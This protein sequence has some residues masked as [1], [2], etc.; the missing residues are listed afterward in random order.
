MA[1]AAL[2]PGGFRGQKVEI[3]AEH[4]PAVKAKIRA[5]WKKFNPD[6]PASDMPEGIRADSDDAPSRV[7]RY[8]AGE[9]RG[10]AEKTSEG[11]LRADAVVTRVGIFPYRREDGSIRRELRPPE[12]VFR[13]DSLRSLM[14][15]PMTSKHP[16]TK[17][18][19]LDADT[20]KRF[21]VGSTGET[22]RTDG[23]LV[24]S[25]LVI[26]DA[27][28]VKAVE[29][30]KRG[31]SCGYECDF[32]P[33]P[34]TWDGEPY[35]GVQRNIVYNHVAANIEFPRA[36]DVAQ[37]HLDSD[38]SPE[39]LEA[40][41]AVQL[42]E[43][44]DSERSIRE[45]SMAD[46][47][48]TVAL[49]GINYQASPEVA[50]ALEKARKD[51]SDATTALDKAKADGAAAL[52]SLKTASETESKTRK[53]ELD[54]VTAE[55]DTLKAKVETLEK[56]RTDEI[57]RAAKRRVHLLDIARHDS[58]KML[59]EKDRE[60]FETKLD[61]MTDAEI[62]RSVIIA[63]SPDLK[64]DDKSEVYIEARFDAIVDGLPKGRKTGSL[65][66]QREQSLRRDA[67]GGSADPVADARARHDASLR[68]AWKPQKTA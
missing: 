24:L 57:T 13:T 61:G 54:R 2:S 31:L 15:K 60:K 1:A 4:L 17:R 34:G 45:D 38:D 11:W 44:K 65:A 5:A 50:N 6:K 12:E 22:L 14:L 7:A 51:A 68:D 46:N 48:R 36:G 43:R 56:T 66:Q 26:T 23:P 49:D 18:G 9:I 20:A 39:S 67:G 16:P 33:T 53:D 3:P 35:D 27:A 19:L 55:R 52:S 32:D 47:L 59:G 42:F 29:T 64:L 41:D 10:K 40:A 37:I 30:G 62:M 8:D 58:F 21:S 25:S 28:A 63:Q